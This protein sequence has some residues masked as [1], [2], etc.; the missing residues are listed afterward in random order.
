[1]SILNIFSKIHVRVIKNQLLHCKENVFSP[2]ISEFRKNY[3]LQHILNH[4]IEEWREYFDKYFVISTVLTDLSKAFDCILHD[5]LIAKLEAYSLGEKALSY[6]FSYLTNWNQCVCIDDKKSNFQK[7]I[8]AVPQGSITGPI[9][10]NFSINNLFFFVSSASIYN[11]TDDNSLSAIAKTLAELKNTLQSELE[12]VIN[13]FK[14]NNMIINLEKVQSI[15][16][17]K[18]KHDYSNETI[19][20]DNK[21]IETVD[22]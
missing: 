19:E 6:I 22:I 18:Q 10:F 11:F 2:Q 15:T 21:R 13:W 1:M 9:L 17:D 7:I 20:F 8:S 14:N 16:S 5:L 4:L 12:V 3:N